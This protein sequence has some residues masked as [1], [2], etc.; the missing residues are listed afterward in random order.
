MTDQC[1]SR[2]DPKSEPAE[3]PQLEEQPALRLDI[4]N[5]AGDWSDIVTALDEIPALVCE[6][7]R[8]SFPPGLSCATVVLS[9]DAH[10]AALNREHRGGDGATNVLSYPAVLGPEDEGEHYLGDVILAHETIVREASELDIPFRAHLMHLTVHGVLHL[11]GFD[12]DDN[13]AARRMERI[14][15]DVLS[16]LGIPDP[17]RTDPEDGRPS[18]SN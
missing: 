11:V 2:S 5:S 17:Y 13:E 18:P 7:A 9:D 16:R 3:P 8:D 15:V 12:H 14:E 10:V 6:R 4:V 1:D